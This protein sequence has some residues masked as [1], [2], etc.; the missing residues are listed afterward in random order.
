MKN[1]LCF[2]LSL[3]VIAMLASCGDTTQSEKSGRV[4]KA[5]IKTTALTADKNIAGI[6][7]IITVPAGVAPPLNSDG[8]V[9]QSATVE[10]LSS[11]SQN[12]RYNGAT[13]IAATTEALG[14]LG[15]YPMVLSGFAVDD[16]ITIH[17]NVAPGTFPVADDFKLVSFVAYDINGA[18][19]AG[20]SPTLTTTIQ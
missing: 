14:T 4:L 13:Y 7:L 18:P 3:L 20:L 12:V 6:E 8:S 5:V 9:N 16:Q 2:I 15:I 1:W 10:V 17:L 11:S 19:V